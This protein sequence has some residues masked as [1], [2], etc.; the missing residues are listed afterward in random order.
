MFSNTRNH[1]QLIW[2]SQTE[3]RHLIKGNI[4]KL[5]HFL[6]MCNHHFLYFKIHTFDMC[7]FYL[8]NAL[9]RDGKDVH[10]ENEILCSINF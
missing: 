2:F 9:V 6:K 4:I 10:D 1:K 5:I 7:G 3:K 8:Y